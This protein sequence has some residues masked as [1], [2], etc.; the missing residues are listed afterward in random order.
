MFSENA[1]K[2]VGHALNRLA[3]KLYK[4]DFRGN[5]VEIIN[6]S[7]ILNPCEPYLD[8]GKT[9]P[10]N[11]DYIK[12]ELNW[13]LSQDLSII[14]HEGIENNKIWQNCA[15]TQHKRVNSNYGNLVF[16]PR[17]YSQYGNALEKL[18]KDKNT[19]QSVMIYNRPE[20]QYEYADR[21]HANHDFTCTMYTQHFI[22]KNNTLTYI[23]NM[24]SN[25]AIFGLQNDYA[26]H[27]YVYFKLLYDLNRPTSKIERSIK[28]GRII[29]HTGSLHVYERH[30]ELLK[31]IM[32]EYTECVITQHN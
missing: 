32:K 24:R 12:N 20:M 8:Y 16:S 4:K 18:I 13:Y 11:R 30:Y 9:R 2:V 29:W 31:N 1:Q 28:I 25:D 10:S 3:K 19:R 6:A 27:R 23:V 5:T 26:W 21:I 14:G 17:N 22:E 7:F 15:T